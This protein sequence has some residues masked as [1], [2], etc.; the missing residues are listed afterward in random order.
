ML[1]FIYKLYQDD[2][3][4]LYLTIA[5]IVLI[6]LF[7][8]VL[9]FGKKDQKLEETKRLQKLEME[10]GFKEQKEEPIKVEVPE[11]PEININLTEEKASEAEEVKLPEEV[12]VTVFDSN[13][14]PTLEV[15]ENYNEDTSLSVN[16]VNNNLDNN[17]PVVN[18]EISEINFNDQELENGLNNLSS[19]RDELDNIKIDLADEAVQAE[20]KI[21]E[22]VVKPNGPQ[23]FSSVFVPEE[24]EELKVTEEVQ[25][26][27]EEVVEEIKIPNM[28]DVDEPDNFELPSLKK[29]N[30]DAVLPDKDDTINLDDISG[31]T[32]NLK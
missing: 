12:N 3:F 9:I 29:D 4:T 1:D 19:I 16:D 8:I 13:E 27:K 28:F 24:K 30:N 5:L 11:V 23:V 21:E 32:Y 15:R 6:V 31:E 20:E 10:D 7:I 22:P 18:E 2:N 17:E 26:P 25:E 14:E